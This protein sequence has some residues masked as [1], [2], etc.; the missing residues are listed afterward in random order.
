MNT[1]SFLPLVTTRSSKSFKL[2]VNF[3]AIS[4]SLSAAAV[5]VFE[6]LAGL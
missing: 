4:Y 2:L 5:T 3:G 1:R 6:A